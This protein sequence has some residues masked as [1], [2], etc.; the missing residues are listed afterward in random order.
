MLWKQL[1]STPITQLFST[2]YIAFSRWQERACSECYNVIH[3]HPGK[4]AEKKKKKSNVERTPE[5]QQERS[6]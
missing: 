2:Q 4:R 6:D 5:G 3:A 1:P